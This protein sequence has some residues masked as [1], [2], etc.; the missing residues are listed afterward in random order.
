MIML[1]KQSPTG[2]DTQ[3]VRQLVRVSKPL[4]LE[5]KLK[6]T[7]RVV[8]VII[9]HYITELCECTSTVIKDVKVYNGRFE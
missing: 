4:Y 1:L 3:V 7:A 6:V 8:S 9:S 5:A 2:Q